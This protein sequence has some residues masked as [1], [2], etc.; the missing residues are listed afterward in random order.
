MNPFKISR[1]ALLIFLS[2]TIATVAGKTP[3]TYQKGTISNI[4]GNPLSCELEGIGIHKQ[5]N[6]CRDFQS[7]QSVDYRVKGD[8]V[9]IRRENGK[10]YKCGLVGTILDNA[11]D[12]QLT[13]KQ[14][15][16]KGWEK[17]TDM[18]WVGPNGETVPRDKTVYE[19]KGADM[20][21]LID[22]CGAFQA[23]KFSLGQIV[24]YRVD[25]SDQNDLRL[26][27]AHDIGQE[28]KCK[29][30]GQKIFEQ[31]KTEVP[32]TAPTSAAPPPAAAPS[33][34]P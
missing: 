31:S 27:I 8:N 12:A 5:I 30:E 22:Y 1:I 16:I 23:G 4:S 10:E 19:L 25:L 33:A 11:G 21:Y 18:I 24:N 29:I 17:G 15:T 34:K 3:P 28:Y 2:T 13:Y 6:N 32:F 20:L 7:G 14:G 26:Y 9:F